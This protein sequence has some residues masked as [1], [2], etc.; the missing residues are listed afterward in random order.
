[1]EEESAPDST[2]LNELANIFAESTKTYITRRQRDTAR[3]IFE[4]FHR[5]LVEIN[6]INTL[7]A[8][9]KVKE[10]AK[11]FDEKYKPLFDKLHQFIDTSKPEDIEISANLSDLNLDGI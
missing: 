1:M 7:D 9:K 8:T 3:I 2:I 10:M 6:A 11:A 5:I 4:D